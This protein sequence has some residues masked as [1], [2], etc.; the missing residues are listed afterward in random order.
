M[1]IIAGPHTIDHNTIYRSTYME[2]M[3]SAINDRTIY[4]LRQVR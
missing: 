2:N 1:E 3:I 4:I